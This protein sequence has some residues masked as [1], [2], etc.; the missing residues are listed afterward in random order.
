MIPREGGRGAGMRGGAASCPTARR[1]PGELREG[2]VALIHSHPVTF[3]RNDD[4][5]ICVH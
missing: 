5:A 2:L 4:Q 1:C 3:D